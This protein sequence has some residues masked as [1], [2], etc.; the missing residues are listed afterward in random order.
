MKTA[1]YTSC[2]HEQNNPPAGTPAG[3]FLHFWIHPAMTSS[4]IMVQYLDSHSTML[5]NV[6]MEVST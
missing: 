4:N 6:T 2:F 3:G 5:Y 1:A